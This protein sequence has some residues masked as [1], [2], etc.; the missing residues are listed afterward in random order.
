MDEEDID[1]STP[2]SF[3]F[4]IQP[5]ME[6]LF[7][8]GQAVRILEKINDEYQETN[9]KWVLDA[10]Q[11][12]RNT[13][14]EATHVSPAMTNQYQWPSLISRYL[15]VFYHDNDGG[16]HYPQDSEE[17]TTYPEVNDIAV[18][19]IRTTPLTY[20]KNLWVVISTPIWTAAEQVVRGW[21]PITWSNTNL[22]YLGYIFAR[23]S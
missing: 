13:H 15:N 6:Y 7:S 12:W 3:R 8:P 22:Q 5:G 23:A 10:M 18:W 4:R 17:I 19:G 1:A 11:L 14:G 9:A 2:G 21:T 20:L 16:E